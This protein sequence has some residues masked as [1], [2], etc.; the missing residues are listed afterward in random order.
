MTFRTIAGLPGVPGVGYP[1]VAYPGVGLPGYG[2]PGI[3]IPGVPGIG[4][5]LLCI[6]WCVQYESYKN[7]ST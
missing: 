3:E 1:G 4:A 7:W 5:Y 6:R 2:E